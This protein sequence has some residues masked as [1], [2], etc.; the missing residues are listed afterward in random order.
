MQTESVTYAPT[1]S[2]SGIYP[3]RRLL[4][5]L[6][7]SSIDFAFW[8][9]CLTFSWSSCD[10]KRPAFIVVGA[11]FGSSNVRTVL[12][13]CLETVSDIV[14]ASAVGRPS[15]VRNSDLACARS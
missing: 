11:S 4:S 6:L 10:I 9:A 2:K 12:V 5:N 7:T 14:V 3:S 8:M 15:A 1:E 13:E